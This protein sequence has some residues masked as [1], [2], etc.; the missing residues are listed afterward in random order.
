MTA[1]ASSPPPVPAPL[2]ALST[3]VWRPGGLSLILQPRLI[4]ITCLLLFLTLACAAFAISSGRISLSLGQVAEILLGHGDG[5]ISERIVL[6]IRLP[7]VLTAI[8]AGAALGIS[9][10]VFQS[11]SRN[12]L[13]SPD[14]I[15]FTTGAATGALM[16]IIVFDQ[17]SLAVALSA[18]LGGMV[19]AAIV[20]LLSV[21]NGAVG[22]YRL[23]LVGI[24]VGAIFNALNGL[25]L[26]KGKLDNAVMAN[27]WLAGSLD[28]RTWQHVLPVMIGTLLLIPPILWSA[29]T[30]HMTEMGDDLASQLGIRVERTRLFMIAYAVVLA[31]LATGAAGPIAFVALAAPQL[32]QRL[33]R[34]RHLPV[35]SAAA[36]GALL[37]MTADLLIQ[38]VPLAMTIPIGRMTGIVGGIYLLWLLTRSRQV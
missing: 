38:H 1:P 25:M 8:F 31:A 4:A 16:Q 32:A 21:R 23:V 9:G 22:G 27:L 37:L 6:N 17:G 13:G 18:V 5:G 26:V 7:R 12:A 30:L 34:A 33:T 20:Y 10:A 35:I 28:A 24:G 36:M 15:G 3:P 2:R 29:R 11:V 14:I 19:T